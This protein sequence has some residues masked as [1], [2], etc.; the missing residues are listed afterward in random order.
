MNRRGKVLILT[1]VAVVVV[2]YIEIF[3][4]SLKAH[5]SWAKLPKLGS[6]SGKESEPFRILIVGDP[7]IQGENDE[8]P[9]VGFITRWDSDRYLQRTYWL[10]RS[11]VQPHAV[12]FMGDLFD[13]GSKAEDAQYRRYLARFRKIFD[14]PKKN[15]P[16]DVTYV[17]LPGDNDVG[18]EGLEPVSNIKLKW[19]NQT[20]GDYKKPVSLHVGTSDIEFVQ[21]HEILPGFSTGPGHGLENILERKTPDF[22]ILLSH[23]S[24]LSFRSDSVQA[25]IDLVNPSLIISAHNHRS[26]YFKLEHGSRNSVHLSGIKNF[27]TAKAESKGF[28][29]SDL[30]LP[31]ESLKYFSFNLNKAPSE[32][33]LH[34]INVPTCSYRMGVADMGYGYLQI[35]PDGSAAYTVLWTPSR[36][37]QLFVYAAF[38][39]LTKIAGYTW[40][41]LKVGKALYQKCQ[42]YR[43]SGQKLHHVV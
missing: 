8:P 14:L 2:L 33:T 25:A 9:L 20:F 36:F 12:L 1:A 43:I 26:N 40:F 27:M 4:Y 3:S 19:F 31:T 28:Q 21:F 6:K 5:L 15:D 39:L 13:E 41:F 24:L 18:G 34:E 22:R 35:Y 11:H 30:V 16:S 23:A 17:F 7:Q 29:E 38:F 42:Q 32:G 37:H 10:A